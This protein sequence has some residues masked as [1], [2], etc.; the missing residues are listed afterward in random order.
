[1]RGGTKRS[2]VPV[3]NPLVHLDQGSL[4]RI[5]RGN[6]TNSTNQLAQFTALRIRLYR[7]PISAIEPSSA[8]ALL[9]R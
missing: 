1:M 2:F 3:R 4:L 5:L 8:A 7:V 9:V 6:L